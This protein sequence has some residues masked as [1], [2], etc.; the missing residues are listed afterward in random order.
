MDTEI[1]LVI[2]RQPLVQV[3]PI[4][5]MVAV[6]GELS[7]PPQHSPIFGHLA[8]SHT[9]ANFKPRSCFFNLSWF[10]LLER[11]SR[12]NHSGNLNLPFFVRACVSAPEIQKWLHQAM[13]NKEIY[14]QWWSRRVMDHPAEFSLL[15]SFEWKVIWLWK[16]ETKTFEL[17]YLKVTFRKSYSKI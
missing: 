14:F 5:M 7:P 12:F 1:Y 8:S 10:W 2:Y 15:K 3:S 11:V 16:S 6:E 9:V 13:S 17:R 4:S